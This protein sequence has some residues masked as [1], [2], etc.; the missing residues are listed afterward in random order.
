MEAIKFEEINL[1]VIQITK[2]KNIIN[3][4]HSYTNYVDFKD[5]C[6]IS[7]KIAEMVVNNIDSVFTNNNT[8]YFIKVDKTFSVKSS[9][10]S[11]E[12]FFRANTLELRNGCELKVTSVKPVLLNKQQI[13]NRA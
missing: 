9:A 13:K 6:V 2:I 3:E 11:N 12:I 7:E 10:K 1:N 5:A 4:K 8:Y